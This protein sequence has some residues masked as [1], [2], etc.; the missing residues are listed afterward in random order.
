[1]SPPTDVALDV[2]AN[3]L[4]ATL[5]DQQLKLVCAESCSGGWVAKVCTDR[6]GS[7]AWFAHGLVVYSNRAKTDLLGVQPDVIEQHGAVSAETA[8]AMAAGA[9]GDVPGRVALAVTGIAGP[10]G[11]TRDKPVGLVWFG[12]ALASGQVAVEAA[13]FPGDRDAVRRASVLMALDGLTRRL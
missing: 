3:R 12:W 8:Q 5:L 2:A 7:S 9:R 6:A 11:A 1:M 10:A 13:R 4:A